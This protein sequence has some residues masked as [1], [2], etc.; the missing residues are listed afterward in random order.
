MRT[1]TASF[2]LP[3]VASLITCLCATP[4]RPCSPVEP[5]LDG[6]T[7]LADGASS[8]PT[9]G[10]LHLSVF[11][12]AEAVTATLRADTADVAN[13]LDLDVEARVVVVHLAP[14]AAQTSYV[15]TLALPESVSFVSGGVTREINIVTGDGAD[16][17]APTFRGAAEVEVA[18]ESGDAIFGGVSSCGPRPA[19]N[20]VTFTVPAIDDDVGVAGLK[21]FQVDDDGLRQLRRF[22]V[23]AVTTITDQEPEPGDYRYQLVAVDVAGNESAPLEIDVGVSGCSAAGARSPMLCALL[24]V[25]ARRRGRAVAKV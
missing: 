6:P 7:S 22:E 10:E 1:P 20:S 21:L 19:T 11:A 14:L 13:G 23:G 16:T 9:N 4:A 15:V 8:V 3:Y 2:A 25:L 17:S 18:H 5:N 24:L 12:G